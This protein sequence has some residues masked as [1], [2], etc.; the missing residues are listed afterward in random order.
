MGISAA[1]GNYRAYRLTGHI[2]ITMRNEVMTLCAL[3]S[4][5]R[6]V[7]MFVTGESVV[8]RG[9][10]GSRLVLQVTRKRELRVLVAN[11]S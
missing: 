10:S 3:Y 5:L 2:L 9:L 1:S 7:G 6:F 11:K 8:V 4:P